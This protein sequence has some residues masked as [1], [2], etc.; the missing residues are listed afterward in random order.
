[1]ACTALTSNV[2]TARHVCGRIAPTGAACLWN[3]REAGCGK[4]GRR[5]LDAREVAKGGLPFS[6]PVTRQRASSLSARHVVRGAA[7]PGLIVIVC[8]SSRPRELSFKGP[9]SEAVEGAAGGS[10]GGG[11]VGGAA[12]AVVGGGLGAARLAGG[13]SARGLAAAA[14]GGEP[15]VVAHG[16]RNGAPAAAAAPSGRFALELALEAF[17]EPSHGEALLISAPGEEAGELPTERER[18]L[19]GACK[20]SEAIRR[21]RVQSEARGSAA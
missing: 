21:E 4:G 14:G 19:M 15:Q 12:G 10:A 5:G 9:S 2:S 6:S 16:A 1:M 7:A 3:G 8:G 17:G 20:Q 13:A 11:A 18:G